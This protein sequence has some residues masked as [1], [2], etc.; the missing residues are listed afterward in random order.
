MTSRPG[1]VLFA[2]DKFRG[3]ASAAT[4]TDIGCRVAADAGWLAEGIPLADGG[5]GSLDVI[6][7]ANK[8]ATVSGPLGQ[9]VRAG[10]RL[11]AQTAFIEMAQASG[12][13][14]VGGRDGNDALDA[15]TTGTGQLLAAALE[16]GAREI[17]VFLGGSA[18]T[19]GGLGALDALPSPSRLK[20]VDLRVA[21]DV[22]TR[23]TDAARVFGPQK[24]ATP[25][26]VKLLTRRLERLVEVY[27]DTYDVDLSDLPGAGA[28]GGLAGALAALGADLESGFE[29]LADRV[30]LDEH[31]SRADLVITGEGRLDPQ[32]FQ[33]KV[34]GG[35]RRWAAE[36]NVPVAAVVGRVTTGTEIPDDM[37]VRSVADL[38]GVDRS[39]SYTEDL[40]ATEIR[41]LLDTHHR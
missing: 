2:F 34:V 32:S 38:H 9:P 1:T 37:V 22:D 16:L 36:A 27:R 19:D 7:G 10:W 29:I 3:T 26:Q 18:T 15:D 23:F 13:A 40:V 24:G 28:A 6:G 20:Q 11:E 35:V 17:I 39:M 30:H 41:H 14:L 12:L 25:A 4:L 33:G 21:C 8:W 5:E 31:L